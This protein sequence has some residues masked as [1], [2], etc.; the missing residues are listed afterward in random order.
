M[1][2]VEIRDGS[3]GW[4]TRPPQ[5]ILPAHTESD[6]LVHAPPRLDTVTLKLGFFQQS[7]KTQTNDYSDL[8]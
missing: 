4:N 7:H 5:D 8:Q 2:E 3:V 6:P 1:R